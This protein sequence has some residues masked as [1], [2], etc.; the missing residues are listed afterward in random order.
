MTPP[1]A[2]TRRQA[3]ALVVIA[4]DDVYEDLFTA[5][6]KLQQ[7]LVHA[8]FAARTAAGTARLAAAAEADL[9]VLY[10]ALGLFPGACQQ[11]LAGAVAAGTG[12]IA[13]HSA[14]V[15]PQSASGG[16]AASHATIAGLIG[17]RFISHGPQPHESRFTVRS[18]AVHTVTRGLAPFD[19]THEHYHLEVAPPGEVIA[20]RPAAPGAV[21]AREPVCCVRRF[22]AGRVCYLQPGHD[23]RVWDEPAIRELF[24][25]AARWACRPA[26]PGEA[27]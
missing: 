14:S 19:I 20:W 6:L 21:P 1:T 18:S 17:C 25:R 13:V 24:A 3:R 5:S 4:G 22:G 27:A 26:G 7:L 16:P 2:L 9:V 10:S 12:L 23:M 8:G 11:A 15:Y